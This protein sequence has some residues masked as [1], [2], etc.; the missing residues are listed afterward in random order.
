MI[1]KLKKI[2]N[3]LKLPTSQG[4]ESEILESHTEERREESQMFKNVLNVKEEYL[5]FLEKINFF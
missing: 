1:C 5:F 3:N 4:I 2:R